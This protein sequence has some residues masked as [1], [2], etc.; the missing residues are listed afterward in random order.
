[1]RLE[2]WRRG[3]PVA[4]VPP[5]SVKKYATGKGNATKPDMRVALLQRAGIDE[6]DDNRVDAWWL[7]SAALDHYGEP[8]VAMP[9]IHREALAKMAWPEFGQS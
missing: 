2:L 1:M 7:R 4:E 8:V 9:R 3:L 6:R 5:S